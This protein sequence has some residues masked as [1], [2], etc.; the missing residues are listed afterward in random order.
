MKNKKNREYWLYVIGL[1]VLGSLYISVL[2]DYERYINRDIKVSTRARV[3]KAIVQHLDSI[4]GPTFV[5]GFFGLI[6]MFFVYKIVLGILKNMKDNS[7]E[8]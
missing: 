4:G 3:F 1:I 5:Y 2:R 8:S 6:A 7:E